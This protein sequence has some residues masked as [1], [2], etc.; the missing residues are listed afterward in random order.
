M[1]LAVVLLQPD[2]SPPPGPSAPLDSQGPVLLIPGY[3]GGTVGL[4]AAASTLG[5]AGIPAEV[6][7]IGDGTGDLSIYAQ[8]VVARAQQ[9]VA[10]GAPSVDLLGFSAGGL[11]ARDAATSTTGQPL[12]RR[13]VTVGSPHE[14]TQLAALGG[15]VGGCPPACLQLSPGSDY[16]DALPTG[17]ASDRW[18]SIWSTTD[19]V[20]RPVA[21]SELK[22]AKWFPLQDVC[23]RPVA[24]NNLITDPLVQNTAI[25]YLGGSGLPTGCVS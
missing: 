6:V 17:S 13:V 2:A 10:S 22:G 8:Q 5:T 24:H 16:L 20:I 12:I 15:L 1:A 25:A 19:E 7:P 11:I 23:A 4:Q 21:S 18:L 3:G 14:G 9:L